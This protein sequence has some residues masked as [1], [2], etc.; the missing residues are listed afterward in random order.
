[1]PLDDALAR[2]AAVALVARR[3]E[4]C[5][6]PHTFG[7]PGTRHWCECCALDCDGHQA[8]CRREHGFC[9]RHCTDLA[10]CDAT[11][12]P[13]PVPVRLREPAD[14]TRAYGPVV[15]LL[16]PPVD[17]QRA[18][19]SVR[20]LHAVAPLLRLRGAVVKSCCRFVS[21]LADLLRVLAWSDVIL[22]ERGAQFVF[23]LL[24]PKE[25]MLF[26]RTR[27]RHAFA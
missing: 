25:T 2:E 10:L 19:K 13:L 12:P 27:A 24:A 4:S 6:A 17:L 16:Q 11:D 22:G 14:S 23:S 20:N 21:T 15:V 5:V 9:Q 8:N 18:T 7:F 26:E 1:M 3:C